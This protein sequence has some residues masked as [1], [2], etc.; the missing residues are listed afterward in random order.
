MT[1]ALKASEQEI[2][3]LKAKLSNLTNAAAHVIDNLSCLGNGYKLKQADLDVLQKAHFLTPTQCLV[4]LIAD[5]I[6]I[7]ANSL[8]ETT[9]INSDVVEYLNDYA[10]KLRGNIWNN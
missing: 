9:E 8:Y 10:D 6:N 5:E 2:K 3:E 4:E 7:A 1:I